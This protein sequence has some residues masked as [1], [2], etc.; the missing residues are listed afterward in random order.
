MGLSSGPATGSLKACRD[1]T[2]LSIMEDIAYG[3]IHNPDLPRC[4]AEL[5]GYLDA[6]NPDDKLVVWSWESYCTDNAKNR[7]ARCKNLQALFGQA[8]ILVGIRNPLKLLESAY[9]Q[10]L[11]RDNIGAHFRKGKAPFYKSIEKWIKDD[12]FNDISNHLQYPETI[13][14]Y[15]EHFGRDQV[16]VLP[17]ELL[18][19]D[20]HRFYAQLCAFMDI[21][22]EEALTLVEHNDDNS[23]WSS[24]QLESLEHI[25]GSAT[26]SFQFRFANRKKRRAMLDLKP[27]GS[28]ATPAEK[29]RAPIPAALRKDI[30][31]RTGEGNRWL[32]QTFGLD[33]E[34]Y[35]YFQS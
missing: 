15:V 32:Q 27:D 23:R 30:L 26:E 22:L 33:L 2:V 16:C 4:A 7:L 24:R 1:R 14:M 34:Q 28:P 17:F 25:T 29:A 3:N 35:G 11:K 21:G 12:R 10:Q 19:A 13:R 8:R 31:E 18:L 5:E 9:F 20:Q 6:H